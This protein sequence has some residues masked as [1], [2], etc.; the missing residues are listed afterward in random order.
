MRSLD[1][2]EQSCQELTVSFNNSFQRQN[3][4]QHITGR[5]RYFLTIAVREEFYMLK[6]CALLFVKAA[7]VDDSH[8]Y[9][10]VDCREKPSKYFSGP[11]TTLSVRK[12][13]FQL[14]QLKI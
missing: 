12:L 14:R 4:K 1:R 10:G 9:A 3:P 7:K 6:A 11:M 8:G 2:A 13:S 5:K